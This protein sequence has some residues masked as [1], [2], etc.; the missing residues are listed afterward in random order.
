MGG[1]VL[2][3]LFTLEYAVLVVLAVI[4]TGVLLAWRT[5]AKCRRSVRIIILAA[6]ALGLACLAAIVLN[7]GTWRHERY[8]K[9]QEWAILID[10][11]LSMATGDAGG[12]PRWDEAVSLARR[13]ISSATRKEQIRVFTFTDRIENVPA[14]SLGKQVADGETTDMV[15]AGK[16]VLARYRSGDRRLSGIVLL[17]DG[18][19]V[20]PARQADLTLDCRSQEAPIFAVPLGGDVLRKDLSITAVRKQYVSF[21]GQKLKIGAMV[22]NS[23]LGNINTTVQL[24]DPAGTRLEEKKIAI[25]ESEPV[26]VQ[27]ELTPGKSGYAE[28]LLK[29]PVWEGET[30]DGNNQCTLGV[31]V[32]QSRMRVFVAEGTPGWDSKF[33]VQLLRKQA[34]MEVT[35]VYRVSSERFFKVETDL[36]KVSESS[37]ALF[38]GSAEAMSLYD[39]VVFCK[40][41]EYF[42]TPERI[43]LLRDFV[44]D[45]GGCVIFSRGK[46][47]NGAFR[48]LE[49]LEP[50]EWGDPVE[51]SFRFR[52]ARS[53]EYAGLFGD[54]LPAGSDPVW[55][56]LPLLQSANRCSGMKAFSQV[57]AEGVFGS[58]GKESS[59]PLVIS[60]R[61]GKGMAVL[62]NAE[63]LWQWDFFPT[64]KEAG[65]MYQELW[66]QL[67]QWAVTYSEFLPGE[68]FSVRLGETSVLPG[69]PV[70]V[71]V[72]KRGTAAGQLSPAVRVFLDKT[73]V[74]Q[75]PATPVADMENRWTA[76]FS[77]TTPG[78]YRVVPVGSEGG[79]EL[80]ACAMLEV[81][82]PP[83]EKDNLSA[84]R[85][86]LENLAAD[87]GGSVLTGEQADK[88][89]AKFESATESADTSKIVWVPLWDKAWVLCIML[90]FFGMEWFVRR[91]NGLL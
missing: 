86:F 64:V 29:I 56:R 54:M 61:Y 39:I 76:V 2:N 60:R 74:R 72:G 38:P 78:V 11:T 5:S 55:N 3:P 49:F 58:M 1:T 14:D 81:R 33:L 30:S 87:S 25:T 79:G 84:D 66:T 48:E 82:P 57:I 17:S 16:A 47:Y 26:S 24:C 91:R 59:F 50:V 4:G 85:A 40:G 77:P 27:F 83:T 41:A 89:A 19:Q 67:L 52:P 8:G 71:R 45:Q 12:K 68:E 65:S 9:E 51:T 46:P 36:S 21:A 15:Q 6:R 13:M 32:L 70:N 31:A 53:G 73:Q 28:Y 80:G 34:N 7:P 37:T 35:S 90:F 75:L 44:R 18:R 10:R 88:I 43:R 23:G 20:T 63:G 69:T 42:L 62:V 22:K